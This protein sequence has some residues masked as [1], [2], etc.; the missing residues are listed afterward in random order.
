MAYYCYL[1]ECA[2]GSYYTGWTLDPARREKQHNSGR[3]AKYTKFHRPVKLVYVEEQPDRTVAM[4]REREL[5]KL[6]HKQKA[7][8]AH[9]YHEQVGMSDQTEQNK[10]KVLSPGRVNLLGEHVDYN[11]GLVLPAAID[12]EVVIEAVPLADGV[13]RVRARDLNE[14]V[15]MTQATIEKKQDVNGQPLPG[16]ALYPAGV[17]H[18]LR[19]YLLDVNGVAAEFSSNLPIGAGLSSSAAVEVGFAV[20]WEKLGGWTIDRMTLAQFCQEAEV[21]Y[22]GV[23]CGLMDQFACANGV[24]DHALL[25]DTRSLDWRPVKLPA[26]TCIVVADSG[27][28]HSLVTSEYNTRHEE[29]NDA[30]RIL[31]KQNA[32]IKALRDASLDDL[33]AVRGKM[34]DAVYRRAKHV[35]SEVTRVFKAVELLDQGDGEGFGRLMVETHASLRDDYEVSCK[36]ADLLVDLA[37]KLPGCLG[38]RITGG[39]FGGCTVNLVKEAF[40]DAFIARLH[41]DYMKS[42]G[43][44]TLIFQSHAEDGARVVA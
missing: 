20:L 37:M 32:S 1:L 36:E 6:T 25:L 21:R 3:G 35:I 27:V 29:C 43:P 13:I 38:A 30:V 7:V 5:K 14:E 31:K 9:S 2:D 19:K 18:V 41:E 17:A 16:W 39:G 28:R 22:V 15:E 24:K 40:V 11:D 4:R 23:N 12:K 10:I 8:L 42:G 26:G 34:S 33:E 44:D